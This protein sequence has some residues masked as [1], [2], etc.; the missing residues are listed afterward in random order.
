VKLKYFRLIKH[1]KSIL[2]LS[3]KEKNQLIKILIQ[4]MMISNLYHLQI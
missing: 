1:S 3:F 4:K 2:K